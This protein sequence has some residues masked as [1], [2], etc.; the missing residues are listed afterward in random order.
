MGMPVVVHS[1]LPQ[2]DLVCC[3]VFILFMDEHYGLFGCF[4]YQNNEVYFYTAITL[5]YAQADPRSGH[6][7][8]AMRKVLVAPRAFLQRRIHA[9]SVVCM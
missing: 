2:A 8:I 6:C 7:G 9:S 5:R 1:V 3:L 4:L